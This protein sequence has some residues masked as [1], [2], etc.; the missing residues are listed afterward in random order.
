LT[1]K[2]QDRLVKFF[3]RVLLPAAEAARKSGRELVPHSERTSESYYIDRSTES[4]EYVSTVDL[5]RTA[6]FLGQKW[7]NIPELLPMA[8]AIQEIILSTSLPNEEKS[9]DV[10]P[11][12]YEMF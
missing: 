8:D 1:D 12:I 6:E 3:E 2:L 11:F 9:G 5:R 7:S 10:S 4:H